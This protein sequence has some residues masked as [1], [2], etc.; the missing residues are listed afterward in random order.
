MITSRLI[1]PTMAIVMIVVIVI[2]FMGF[3]VFLLLCSSHNRPIRLVK[4]DRP[5]MME[6]TGVSS[7]E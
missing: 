4:S 2:V 5:I 6:V 3:P 7:S 1:P